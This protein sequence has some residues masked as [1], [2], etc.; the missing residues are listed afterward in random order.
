M[1]IVTRT[2]FSLYFVAAERRYNFS[3]GREPVVL[4]FDSALAPLG[5]AQIQTSRC[6]APTGLALCAIQ[7]HGLAP[8]ANIVPPLRGC[9]R[10]HSKLGTQNGK[11]W[12]PDESFNQ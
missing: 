12:R 6:A 9:H 2:L 7:L 3:H 8:V 11:G 1:A 4:N 10:S 5:A